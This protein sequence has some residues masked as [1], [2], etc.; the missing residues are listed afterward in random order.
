MFQDEE[1]LAALA[2]EFV[3]L[4]VDQHVHRRMRDTEGAWFAHV[5]QQAGRGLGGRS[6]G[7]YIFHPNGSLLAFSNTA[8]A[9]QVRRLLEQAR[10]GFDEARSAEAFDPGG[11]DDQRF[12]MQPPAGTLV[13]TVASKVL[14]GF[15][16]ADLEDRRTRMHADSVGRDHLWVRQDEAE[17]LAA[18]E[19]PESL[20]VRIARF[21]L[22]DNTRGE[23]PF[24][25]A[26]DVRHAEAIIEPDGGVRGRV[27]LR[28]G[29]G[30]RSYRVELAGRVAADGGGL[31]RFDLLATGLYEGHGTYT[32][33]APEG[34]FPF[35]VSFA[36]LGVDPPQ[37]VHRV[38]P[39]AARG[40]AGSYLGR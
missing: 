21:H 1:V 14:G 37:A 24:W 2:D 36:M 28:T 27:E 16:E 23:P 19:F 29:D 33:G 35:A 9:G 10:E 31:R 5:L 34:E 39:G 20:L 26:G 3:P 38:V 40:G 30:A 4:A 15:D 11:S 25:G 17:A 32:R 6:Q 12:V 22:I 13:M 18:G 8:D 7:V